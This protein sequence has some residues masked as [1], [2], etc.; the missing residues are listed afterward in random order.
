MERGI[1]VI[2]A[3]R[4]LRL[5]AFVPRA[6][7][8]LHPIFHAMKN[9]RTLNAIQESVSITRPVEASF[10]SPSTCQ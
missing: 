10:K 8:L 5:C 3:R 1:A 7:R 6:L 2:T 9:R 4:L